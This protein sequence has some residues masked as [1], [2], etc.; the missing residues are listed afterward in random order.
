MLPTAGVEPRT[1]VVLEIP[2]MIPKESLLS[3]ILAVAFRA[4]SCDGDGSSG[5]EDMGEYD[6]R[7]GVVTTVVCNGEDERTIWYADAIAAKRW[8]RKNREMHFSFVISSSVPLRIAYEIRDRVVK[9]SG[10]KYDSRDLVVVGATLI[11]YG[12]WPN[13]QSILLELR[14]YTK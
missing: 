10:N 11:E 3:I 14:E 13:L 6:L 12:L 7:K 2:A 8:L 1:A 5:D 9:P 4:K